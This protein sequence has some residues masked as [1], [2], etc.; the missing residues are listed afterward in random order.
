[1]QWNAQQENPLVMVYNLNTV[2]ASKCVRLMTAVPLDLARIRTS[3]SGGTVAIDPAI[4]MLQ[5][6]SA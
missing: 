1:M 5:S 4:Q 3:L 6:R 2:N